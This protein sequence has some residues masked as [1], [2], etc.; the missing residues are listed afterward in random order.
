LPEAHEESAPFFKHHAQSE[1]PT[2]E[3][4]GKRARVIAGSL[5]GKKSPVETYS[6]MFYADVQLD[7]GASLPLDAEHE[8]RG[9]YLVSGEIEVA[10]DRFEPGR[11]LVFR[12]GVSCCSVALIWGLV[13]SGGI[14]SPRAK[15]ASSRRRKTGKPAASALSQVTTRNSSHCRIANATSAACAGRAG[16]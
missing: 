9:L 4:G 1:L 5:W 13:T 16:T 2:I 14:S 12:P 3:A 8:E 11:L 15:I 7:A 6:E 10:G